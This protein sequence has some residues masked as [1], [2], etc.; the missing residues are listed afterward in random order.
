MHNYNFILPLAIKELQNYAWKMCK[1]RRQ[2]PDIQILFIFFNIVR[3]VRELI[4]LIEV[5]VI[6]NF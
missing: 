4:G 5:R 1:N 6:R 2:K 3:V